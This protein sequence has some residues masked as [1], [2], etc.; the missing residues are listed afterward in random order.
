MQA[1]IQGLETMLE[2]VDGQ[3]KENYIDT[4][5]GLKTMIELMSDEEKMALGG[6]VD[7]SGVDKLNK[8]GIKYTNEFG[9]K[10][11]KMVE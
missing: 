6:N 5:E 10:Y 9:A 1:T 8:L 4:I 11:R 3:E 2:F 7:T